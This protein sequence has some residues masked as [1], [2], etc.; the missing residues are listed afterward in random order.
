MPSQGCLAVRC[1]DLAGL[2]VAGE[3]EHLVEAPHG[4]LKPRFFFFRSLV[5]AF[6]LVTT[7]RC[8]SLFTNLT[9]TSPSLSESGGID[10]CCFPF[11]GG[12]GGIGWTTAADSH[13]ANGSLLPP[14]LFPSPPPPN[15]AQPA[16][17]AAAAN[18]AS[19]GAGGC[20]EDD[21][22]LAAAAR[23]TRPWRLRRGR[24]VPGGSSRDS[25]G[26]P[27]HRD[28]PLLLPRP[29]GE[30]G[31]L[32]KGRLEAGPELLDSLHPRASVFAQAR[33]PDTR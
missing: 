11:S 27:E 31:I 28:F 13:A 7:A 23:T 14:E 26:D 16:S 1:L 32:S 15:V 19:E 29:H 10:C 2:G 22:S 3:L 8:L 17:A 25:R 30:R 9:F 5:L 24:R 12:I 6:A 20:G 21:A 4:D 33:P 18:G